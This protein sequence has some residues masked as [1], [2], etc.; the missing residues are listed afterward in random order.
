MSDEVRLRADHYLKFA[1][2]DLDSDSRY[3]PDRL[4][5]LQRLYNLTQRAIGDALRVNPLQSPTNDLGTILHS[6]K[7]QASGDYNDARVV[8][9]QHRSGLL[10]EVFI[11]MISL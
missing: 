6:V 10:G 7:P 9:N 4:I 3:G 11:T 2:Q 1:E 8:P 5:D